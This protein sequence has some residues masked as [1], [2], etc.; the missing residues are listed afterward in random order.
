[1]D[2]LAGSVDVLGEIRTGM[3]RIGFGEVGIFDR[4]RSRSVWRVDGRVVFEG[5]ASLGH[6]TRLSIDRTGTVLFGSNFVITAE[7]SIVCRKAISF[8]SGVLVSWDVLIMDSDWHSVLDATGSQLNPDKDVAI[9]DNVWIGCRSTILKGV[10]VADGSIVAAGSV[11]TTE[12]ANP[13]SLIAGVPA[14]EKR[15][16]LS[17][18]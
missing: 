10:R 2:R 11:V 16:G 5:P 4:E 6:G 17:W 9:G 8:G 18:Q 14:R 15:T 1:L 12:F 7:A 3:I 13:N